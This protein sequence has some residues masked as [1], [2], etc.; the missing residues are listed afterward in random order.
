[1]PEESDAAPPGWLVASTARQQAGPWFEPLPALPVVSAGSHAGGPGLTP[2]APRA[3]A[4]R[5]GPGEAVVPVPVPPPLPMAA[6]AAPGGLAAGSGAVAAGSPPLRV[7]LVPL[8][9]VAMASSVAA[10]VLLL[11]HLLRDR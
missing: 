11:L 1:M 3:E 2:Y 7:L 4:G 5:R 8:V 9:V 10:V 6:G